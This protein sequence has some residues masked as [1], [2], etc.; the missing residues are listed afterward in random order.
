MFER[1]TF[2]YIDPGDLDILDCCRNI[3]KFTSHQSRK[4]EWCR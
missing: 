3:W 1:E 4:I 2:K